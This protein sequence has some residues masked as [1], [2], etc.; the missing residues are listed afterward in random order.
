MMPKNDA[1]NWG[2]N[3]RLQTGDKQAL[4][5]EIRLTN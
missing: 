4:T 2:S 3:F 5:A 1:E